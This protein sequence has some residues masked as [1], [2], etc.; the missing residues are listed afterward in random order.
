M[1]K[2]SRNDVFSRL[3]ERTTRD[4][5][6]VIKKRALEGL[7]LGTQLPVTKSN[8]SCLAPS[9]WLFLRYLKTDLTPSSKRP[10]WVRLLVRVKSDLRAPDP[11]Y[12]L[13]M[14]SA[15]SAQ[16]ERE[17]NEPL[18]STL[19]DW[20]LTLPEILAKRLVV[21]HTFIVRQNPDVSELLHQSF[22]RQSRLHD[23][24]SVKVIHA[25][26]SDYSLL[27]PH[28]CRLVTTQMEISVWSTVMS[29]HP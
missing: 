20:L 7:F 8:A 10:F 26:G 4:L 15:W 9:K 23:V 13:E 29:Y 18:L 6:S 24:G 27:G 3:T 2:V 19:L 16:T 11:A 22:F 21:V 1:S 5:G 17:P 25:I 12:A 28:W 14:L